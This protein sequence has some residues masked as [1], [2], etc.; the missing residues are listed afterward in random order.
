[1]VAPRDAPRFGDNELLAPGVLLA[2]EVVSPWGHRRD[3]EGKP[4]AYAQGGVPLYLV[5]DWFTSPSAVAL[6]SQPGDNGYGRRQTA[7]KGQPLRPPK[8]FGIAL[9]TARLLS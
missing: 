4:R 2:A 1:M 5:I 7:A 9:D 8:P 3:R 6:F